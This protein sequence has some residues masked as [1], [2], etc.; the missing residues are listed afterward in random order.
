M[1]LVA[2]VVTSP[3]PATPGVF[4]LDRL[5]LGSVAGPENYLYTAGNSIYPDG[6]IDA[7]AFYYKVVVTDTAGTVRNPAFPCTPGA[8]FTT[9]NNSYNVSP[10]DPVSNSVYWKFTLQQFANSSCTGTPAKSAFLQFDVAKLTSWADP[11]LTTQK[12]VFAPGSSV[13]VTAAGMKPTQSNVSNTWSLPSS[14]AACGNTVGGDRANIDGFGRL[15]STVGGYLL[16]AP[17]GSSGP[18]WN[19][20][21]SYDGPCPAFGVANEGQWSLRINITPT[22]FVTLPAF[23][24][25][26]TPPPSPS[27]DSGPP[28][29]S[30]SASAQFTFSDSEAGVSFGC[31]LD[32]GSYTACTSPKSY[33]GLAEG[34]H[35]FQVVA[36]DAAGNQSSAA[37][38][39]WTIDTT[40]P[41]TTIDSGPTGTVSSDNASFTFSS[42]AGAVF[43]C[44]L[45][46]GG[47]GAC[48]SPKAYSGLSEGPHTFRVRAGD[49][50]G[51]LDPS[52]AARTWTVDT[53]APPVP[54]IDS[55]PP[56]PSGSPNASFSFSDTESGV[57]FRCR[58]DGG[59]FSACT[60]PKAYSGLGEGLHTFEVFALD[61]AGNESAGASHTWTIDVAPVVTL[62]TPADGSSTNDSTPT[63]SGTAGTAFGDSATVTV[64]VYAG[65]APSGTPVQT[66]DA[67]RDSFGNWSIDASDPLTTGTY[68]AQAEQ[69]DLD[70]NVGLSSANTFSIDATPPPTPTI[71]S[72]PPNL[73]NSASA[74]FTFSDSEAGV[75]FG[76]RLDGGSYTACTSPKS[77]SGLAEG[78]HTFQVV[79]S[80]A[81]G[82]QSSAASYNWTIDTTAPD[83]TIDSGPTGTVSSDNASFTFSSEAGAVFECELDGGGFGACT[84]PKAYS[85]LSEGPHTFRV[86]A[87]DAAGNLDPSPAARTWTVDTTAPD[88]TIDSGPTGT[89]S[90]DNAS[91]TF[92]S[93]AG[94]VFECE[95]DGGGFGACTSPKAY[96]GLS[97]GPHT[98]RVRAGDA[99][100]NLDPSPAARTWTVD[101]TAPP[102]PSIDSGP[103]DP[104][105]SPNA[106]FSFS[107]TESG[108]SFRCR[109]DG[110]SFSACTSPKAYSGLGEGLHTFEVF[111]LDG[112][113]N[114]SAGASHTWTIDVAPVVTLATPADGS[115][116]NDSTPTFV[117]P[118]AP[119]S[120][121]RPRSRSRSTPA[122]L[123][124]G[125][126]YRRSTR[127]ATRSATGRSTPPIRSPP[128]RTRR[129]RSRATSA[130]TS[131]S[132]TR[133]R[134]T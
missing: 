55:G 6:G 36:S 122:R 129:R 48:T 70:G 66:L 22:V 87:G 76:C 127:R 94:A 41:D 84:S 104:S 85:G 80:D 100:G 42:E 25:D 119:P 103:P 128:G 7:G 110:G 56:D 44:E 57:S 74:Q 58:L 37:S 18:Q 43:E 26:A 101:T 116:T 105:S 53:T 11:A 15:P 89:V 95:L 61:G 75:S 125:R 109:L 73:S 98:F 35:T 79:A 12:S 50:A 20:A 88:T 17:V 108:V 112:A 99:A 115:S 117:A 23:T 93:E 39:N 29:L 65:P 40:A 14:A 9:A 102:V 64:K 114:E 124:A 54:S 72:G 107:D 45:D 31:R 96:S 60:S 77:Y 106:S 82:N 69:S 67:T 28:N 47:F 19:R 92:S 24:V 132:A 51:N 5:R 81:A 16:Y 34:G 83:T 62:A 63:F 46:G 111:A 4:S 49:A 86:R 21:T 68:T 97:E 120:A 91:F 2:I 78:G 30:N 130:K 32:G 59:S 121:T 133:T 13:Y 33:S 27:I 38:Y 123:R 113:G 131:A 10:S 3:A 90:S 8:N 1:A 71:D 52:P 134:S 126:R 118:R